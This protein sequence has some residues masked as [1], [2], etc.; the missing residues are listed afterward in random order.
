[1]FTRPAASATLLACSSRLL[2]A[3]C[4]TSRRAPWPSGCVFTVGGERHVLNF[5]AVEADGSVGA[6]AETIIKIEG[7]M[8][9]SLFDRLPGVPRQPALM[10]DVTQSTL[11]EFVGYSVM[12]GVRDN[13]G[14]TEP[15]GMTIVFGFNPEDHDA[16]CE[17][18]EDGPFPLEFFNP[19]DGGNVLVKP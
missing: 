2:D 8:S 15:D 17:L 12:F 5:V 19:L 1:M 16:L 9:A 18:I 14:S 11:P 4:R 10:V 3:W 13:G 6:S 7:A